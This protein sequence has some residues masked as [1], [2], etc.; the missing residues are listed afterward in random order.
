ME[1]FIKEYITIDGHSPFSNWFEGLEAKA[2]AK[3]SVAIA[4][5]AN[6]NFSNSKSV[7]AGVL[8]AK[9]DFGPGSRIYYGKEDKEIIILLIGGTKKQQQQD[10]EKA[11]YYW[12][13]FKKR[14][15]GH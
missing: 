1:F 14:N 15:K 5:M 8:E 10:I 12:H 3:V 6:G 13:E 9:I 2:A 4:R 7:G 11:K